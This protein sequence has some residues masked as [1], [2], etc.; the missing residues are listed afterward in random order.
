MRPL[1]LIAAFLITF[2]A[3]AQQAFD[4]KAVDKLM[5][6][7]L[8][9]W[10][11]PGAA[12]AIVRN[13]RVVYAKGYGTPDLAG[14]DPV[15]ADTLFQ[16]ASTSKAFTTTAL[17]ML[18][19]EGKL[20]WD[21][22]VRKHLPYFRLDD[23]CADSQVTI[24]DIVSHRSG[25]PRQDELW[26]N[27]PLT[28]EQVIRGI[29]EL[30]LAKPFRTGYQ[31]NN[32]MFIVAGE[33]I[34]NVSGVP[35]EEFVRT[36]IF[37]PLAMTRTVTSDADWNAADHAVGHRWDAK[38]G[39]VVVQR[40]IETA[41]LGSAGAIKSSARDMANWLRFQL[42]N[43]AFDLHQLTDMKQIEETKMPHTPIRL[44]NSTRDLNPETHVMSYALGWNVQ[45]YRGELLVSHSGALNGFR[46]HVDL[47]PKRAS[48]FV[49]M[50]NVGR[51]YALLALR[52]SLADML[53]GKPGRD[54]NA[55]Y[56]MLDQRA[57]DKAARAKEERLASAPANATPSLPLERYAGEYESRSHGKATLSIVDGRLMLA[58][59]RVSIPLVHLE[60][61]TFIA[62]SELDD[63]DEEVTF[64]LDAKRNVA[65][66]TIFG[67][68][69]V[70][71]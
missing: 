29:S 55:Y 37:T 8:K 19:A 62:E 56:L 43:G 59:S 34:A 31:Y 69:F 53:S 1:T 11:I 27:S 26:D 65:S 2:V 63:V 54:W 6:A 32:I 20:S 45:D 60:Y 36:R 39:R 25:A 42:S 38:A 5:R 22:P 14:T 9:A 50:A 24:R 3:S 13:D 17:A 21:D 23:L 16:I 68:T 41:V 35:W 58:W 10:Q 30:R 49:V 67:T 61:D 28:R 7:T 66:F 51:G 18:V 70:K 46:T 44:E 71:R 40:P 47:L 12:V 15:T 4:T 64:T 33:V 52:N 57:D 48:G